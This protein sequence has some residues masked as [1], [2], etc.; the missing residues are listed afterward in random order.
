MLVVI[1][2]VALWGCGSDDD[3]DVAVVT[4]VVDESLPATSASDNDPAGDVEEAA[5]EIAISDFAFSGDQEVPV[6]GRVVVT[7]TDAA[8]H[9]WTAVDGSFDSGTL[10]EGDSF[11]F[12]FDEPG[13][14]EYL[15]SIHPTMTGSTT[16]TG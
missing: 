3:P 11:E 8:S 7:N 16:V 5:V 9:T 12:V 13:T 2:S 4:S 14:F 1:G 15:C 10:A 6:G